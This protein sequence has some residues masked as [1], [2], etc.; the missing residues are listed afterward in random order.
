M[1]LSDIYSFKLINI[2]RDIDSQV[3]CRILILFKIG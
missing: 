1:R 2:R 3:F